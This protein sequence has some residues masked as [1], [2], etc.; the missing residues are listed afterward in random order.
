MSSKIKLNRYAISNKSGNI[1]LF[2]HGHETHSIHPKRAKNSRKYELC[3]ATTLDDYFS[4]IDFNEIGLLKIDVEGAEFDVLK[5]AKRLLEK[6]KN[7]RLEYSPSFMS[8]S[9]VVNFL[10]NYNFSVSRKGGIIAA[11]K[12]L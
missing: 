3:P 9:E 10:K 4:D 7:V 2:L 8:E 1:K 5:G 6:V 12:R 11:D